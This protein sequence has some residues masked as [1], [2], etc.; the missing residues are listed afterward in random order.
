MSAIVGDRKPLRRTRELPI[1]RQKCV[2]DD[3]DDDDDEPAQLSLSWVQ[4]ELEWMSQQF[5]GDTAARQPGQ[6]QGQDL[7]QIVFHISYA[8]RGEE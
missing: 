6:G 2:V 3:A 8:N 5:I 4:P 1:F 7:P